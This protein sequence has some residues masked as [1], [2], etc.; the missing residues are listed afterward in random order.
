MTTEEAGLVEALLKNVAEF[1]RPCKACS[2][3]LFFVRHRNGKITP[4][5]KQAVNHFINCPGAAE[6]RAKKSEVKP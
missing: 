3:R 1:E 4:Y 5:T 2:A 6:F